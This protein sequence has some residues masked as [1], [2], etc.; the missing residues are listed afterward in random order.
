MSSKSAPKKIALLIQGSRNYERGV[1]KGIAD[2]SNQFGPWQFYRQVPPI[3][4][5]E[6]LSVEHIRHWEPDAMIIRESP[7]SEQ[8]MDLGIPTIYSPATAYRPGV[9]NIY[10][11]DHAVGRMA[12]RHLYECGLRRFAYC[13]LDD[14]F[15]WSKTRCEAFTETIEGY[16]LTVERYHRPHGHEP[17][18]WNRDFSLLREW[19]ADL[20][21]PIGLMVCNDDFS[22]FVLE[23]CKVAQ[24][25]V[26]EDIAIIGVGNDEAVCELTTTPLSSIELNTIRGGYDCAAHLA[27]ILDTGTEPQD[28]IIPPIHVVQRRSTDVVAASDPQVAEA[29]AFIR[30]SV[31]SP[32]SV[33]DVVASV[34]I[35]RRSLYNRFRTETGQSIYEYVRRV[36]LE[37]FTKMLLDT[38]LNISEIAYSMG[39]DSDTN[40][41]R[42]FRQVK[43]MTPLAYRKKY[44]RH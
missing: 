2:Y 37:L 30:S 23:A 9:P 36:R 19:L 26:P 32:I 8:F 4:G 31:N 41:S 21:T 17:L 16:G 40:V 5:G 33:D 6:Q 34:A 39:Y 13:G 14:L 28:T 18:N 7:Y 24:R 12:A 11:D 35:S 20:P 38:N 25:R 27:E 29:I 42:F 22:L 43:G 44:S 1:L 3:S 10:V 15:F